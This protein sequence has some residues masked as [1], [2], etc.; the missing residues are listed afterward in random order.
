MTVLLYYAPPVEA[1]G[2]ADDGISAILA[3][4]KAQLDPVARAN[5]ALARY[6]TDALLRAKGWA[7]D[8]VDSA[9]ARSLPGYAAAFVRIVDAIEALQ[10]AIERRGLASNIAWCARI[11]L[12]EATSRAVA[13]YEEGFYPGAAI[14]HLFEVERSPIRELLSVVAE[15]ADLHSEMVAGSRTPVEAQLA[16]AEALLDAPFPPSHP[17]L[18][19]Q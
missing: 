7:W 4:R 11:I 8:H 14:D 10:G 3:R 5:A 19:T 1:D 15:I 17:E 9:E 12:S 2:S 13:E 6:A 16:G 18:E